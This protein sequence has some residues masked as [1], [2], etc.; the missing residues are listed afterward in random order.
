MTNNNDQQFY[1]L[2]SKKQVEHLQSILGYG[3]WFEDDEHVE[4]MRNQV[5]LIIDSNP[6][7]FK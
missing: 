3:T 4:N 2:L 1:I 5:N 7:N 6:K